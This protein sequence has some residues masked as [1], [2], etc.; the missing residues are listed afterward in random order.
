MNHFAGC[1][2]QHTKGRLTFLPLP[3]QKRRRTI[4]CKMDC[5]AIKEAISLK[6][7]NKF[8]FAL[9]IVWIVVGATLCI[10]FSE[11]EISESRYDIRCHVTGNTLNIDLLRGSCYD[12]YRI[13]NHKLGI[14]P[15]LFMIVNVLL[16]PIV[17]VIY[18]QYAKSTVNE[19]ERN[20]QDAQGQPRNRRR[21]LFIAYLCQLI[22][23]IVLEITFIVLLETQLFYPR[24]FPSDFSCSIETPSFN[25]TQ[26]PNL[27]NC[28]NQRAGYKNALTTFV[29]AANGVFAF[30][31]FLEIIRILSRARNGKKFMENWQFYAYHLRSN[32]DEQ[33]QRQPDGIPLVKPQHGDDFHSAIQTL[34]S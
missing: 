20:P 26:S 17:T 9:V 3:D 8:T 15:Y 1:Q 13:H 33:R 10:A 22:I 28:Y 19:L 21:T 7:L 25:G 31:A 34:R 14:P 32:S 27:F 23:S 2:S 29:K 30:F 11:L 5:T 24:N 16:I 4:K 6:T 12:Q 18:S